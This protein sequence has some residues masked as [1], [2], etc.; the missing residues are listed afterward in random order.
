MIHDILTDLLVGIATKFGLVAGIVAVI[1]DAARAQRDGSPASSEQVSKLLLRFFGLEVFDVVFDGQG[2]HH[3]ETRARIV[4][5]GPSD[6]PVRAISEGTQDAERNCGR[7][8]TPDARDVLPRFFGKQLFDFSV[9][10]AP[11][12]RLDGRRIVQLSM[13]R[14]ANSDAVWDR[15]EIKHGHSSD[16]NPYTSGSS[17]AS[18]TAPSSD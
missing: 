7:P 2:K 5:N 4:E 14:D 18:P 15:F 12:R 1:A 16:L 9:D 8:R 17:A 6:G 3:V 11:D 13:A 10:G